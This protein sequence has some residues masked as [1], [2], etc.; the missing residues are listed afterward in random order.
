M[1]RDSTPDLRTR[2][3]LHQLP[4]TVLSSS[5][6]N[7][8]PG[9]CGTQTRSSSGIAWMA[10][11]GRMPANC[12][13]MAKL[14]WFVSGDEIAAVDRQDDAG[15]EACGRAGEKEHRAGDVVGR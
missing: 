7:Q 8:T 10:I 9:A 1:W 3:R 13:I 5:G 15:D 12:T 11:S 2:K 6:G 4:V 14:S